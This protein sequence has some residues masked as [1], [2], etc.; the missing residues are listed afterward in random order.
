LKRLN[1]AQWIGAGFAFL[2]ATGFSFKAILV[3]LAYLNS[4]VDTITL[5]M[6]RMVFS[7]PF[8]IAAAIWSETDAK[9]NKLSKREWYAV[10]ILGFTGYYLASYLDFLGLNYVSA[11]FERLTLYIY[12]TFVILLSAFFLKKTITRHHIIALLM[13]YAGIA[14]VFFNDI[15]IKQSFLYTLLGTVLVLGS[16]LAYAI[17]LIGNEK[18]AASIGTLRFTAY[19]MIVSSVICILQFLLTHPLNVALTL[20]VRVYYL[21]AAMA[22]FSTVLPIFMMSEG[23]RRIGADR[24]SLISS[25]GPVITIFFGFGFLNEPITLFQLL[26]TALILAGIVNIIK[27]R[28]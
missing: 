10:A 8:F 25:A 24:A 5:L 17:Y 13:S 28:A 23:I 19:A 26:G 16:A 4:T 9:K 2:S 15:S 14:L 21:T 1:S 3:K 11:G 20:P 7:L 27:S 12:P 18:F 22:V 6:L